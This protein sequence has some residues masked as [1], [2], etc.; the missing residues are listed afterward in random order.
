MLM[1]YY[2]YEL[3]VVCSGNHNLLINTISKK[4]LICSVSEQMVYV[5][6]MFV[7]RL[8][9][10][11]CVGDIAYPVRFSFSTEIN[12]LSSRKYK[13]HWHRK[14]RERHRA[15]NNWMLPWSR[16]KQHRSSVALS[17]RATGRE[18]WAN[19]RL[20]QFAI[21]FLLWLMFYLVAYDVRWWRNSEN[22]V[23][24]DRQ[25]S[26]CHIFVVMREI[27]LTRS[28]QV[29]SLGISQGQGKIVIVP[30]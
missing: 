2:I 30:H 1:V 7:R 18:Y 22:D 9:S 4:M 27:V 8:R 19:W 25:I 12:G 16:T 28:L 14:S 24:R 5:V 6:I 10:F 21:P 3:T 17:H 15:E 23:P 29:H 20:L 13:C 11:S 26:V